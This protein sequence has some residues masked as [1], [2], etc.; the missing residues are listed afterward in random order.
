MLP[1]ETVQRLFP[2]MAKGRMSD[3]MHQRKRLD[4]VFIQLKN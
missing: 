3:V 4:Q 2:S 1:H